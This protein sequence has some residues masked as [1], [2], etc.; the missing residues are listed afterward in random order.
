M[1][2]RR[3]ANG[4]TDEEVARLRDQLAEGRRPRVALSGPQFEAGASGSVIRIGD[5]ATDGADF[6]TVRVKV[7]GVTDELAFAPSELSTGRPAAK[8]ARAPGARTRKGPASTGTALS[9]SAPSGSAPGSALAGTAASEAASSEAASSGAA[10][11]GTA[12]SAI[13]PSSSSRTA[14]AK[15]AAAPPPQP[16]APT[17]TPAGGAPAAPPTSR[18]GAAG[19]RRKVPAAPT[20]SVTISSSGAT[21]AVSASRGART[22]VKNAPVTP[23]LVTALADLLGQPG[24]S[25][26]VAEI[27]EAAREQARQRAEQLRAELSDLEAV[28]ATHRSPR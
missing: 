13:A 9:G 12:S 25:E 26:A 11:S 24:V 8:P 22:I 2:P 21:W 17:S 3:K 14:A 15:K 4:L 19:R 1:P 27:N 5:P 16:A 23:G 7:N 18:G 28:L 20:V 6:L 10:S